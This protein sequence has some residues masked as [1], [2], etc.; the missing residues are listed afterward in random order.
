MIK[1]IIFDGGGV[2][3]Y[4]TDKQMYSDI[5]KSFNIGV[6]EVISKI[7][8]LLEKFERGDVSHKNMWKKFSKEVNKDLPSDYLELISRSHDK[9]SKINDE[10]INFTKE[11]KNKG[12]KITILS[13]TNILHA[14][15]NKKR[16][17]FDG[18]DPI[19]LS[20]EVHMFKPDLEIYKLTVKKL[21]LKPEECV[22]VDDL[23]VNI[24][25]ARKIGMCGVCFRNIAQLKEDLR[26]L[27]IDI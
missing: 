19:I 20:Y 18:F 13:N 24:E 27:K 21:G 11:L 10:M 6:E 9:N 8:P 5:A 12:Y 2:L 4:N 15:F 14:E 26:K 3:T 22:F 1:A 23:E 17:L 7:D 16:G 25:G